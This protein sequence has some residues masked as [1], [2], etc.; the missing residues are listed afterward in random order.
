MPF[1][2]SSAW[3]STLQSQFYRNAQMHLA[4]VR[5]R[6]CR[7]RRWGNPTRTW[8]SGR[9]KP[10]RFSSFQNRCQSV[11]LLHV[12]T[13]IIFAVHISN[14]TPVATLFFDLFAN[15]YCDQ[16][17]K[18]ATFIS[19]LQNSNKEV[20]TQFS[21]KIHHSIPCK[22]ANLSVMWGYHRNLGVILSLG[23]AW[24]NIEVYTFESGLV[25]SSETRARPEFEKTFHLPGPIQPNW[26]LSQ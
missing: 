4:A 24:K 12:V 8:A 11:F 18:E 13:V 2:T 5:P 7:Y 9:R 17:G 15:G 1:A 20:W 23:P 3:T 25:T 19:R 26:G 6:C 14:V 22:H 21:V 16:S 10:F